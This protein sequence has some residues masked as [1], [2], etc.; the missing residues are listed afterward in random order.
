MVILLMLVGGSSGSCAGG[1]KTGTVGVLLL[2]LRSGLQ[3]RDVVTFRGRTIPDQKVLSA[4][5]LMLVFV[6]LFI[7]ASMGIAIVDDVPYLAAAYETASAM[8]TVGVTTGITPELS[9][10]SHIILILLMYL[11]RVGVLSLSLAF[12]TQKKAHSKIN[13]PHADVMIG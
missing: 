4:M 9:T 6:F 2:A 1:L 8:A 13:Y 12:M 3:G 10:V 7:A 11:G 5:T